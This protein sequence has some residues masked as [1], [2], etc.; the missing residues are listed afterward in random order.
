MSLAERVG[1]LFMVDCP[2]T[3]VAAATVRAI[4]KYHVG[5]VILDGNSELSNPATARITRQ[6][7]ALSPP[8]VGLFVAADQEGG[9]VQRL[10]GPGFSGIPSAVRQGTLAPAELRA[11][12]ARWGRELRSAG[13]NVN[14]APVLDT[15][16]AGFG[17]NPPIGDVNREFGHTTTAVTAHGIAVAR[18]FAD[19][20]IVATAK[21]FPG[22]GRVHANT[23]TAAGV[24][25]RV[26]VR[27]D[28]YLAPF[29]A[30]VR[31][32]VPFVMMSTAVYARIDPNRPA[33]FSPTIVTG[34]L[35]RR[36]GF[37]G[38]VISDD[39][40]RASQVAAYPAGARA[41]QF[42][43]AGGDLVITVD[44]GRIPAMTA[45][46]IGR[47]AADPDFARAV[48]NAALRVLT[49]KQSHGLL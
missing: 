6:L 45:A 20:G 12:A 31:A 42:V 34:M 32:G 21:H 28:P 26:T 2:S 35:R 3:G 36:L 41:V 22:L 5:S 47:A 49:A 7:Q 30:A 15:V 16:P 40:G 9:Q 11:R 33:A 24:T 14:L 44:P 1:Q 8:G 10:R 43:A 39:L 4:E 25:D 23:D 37:T 18:G 17:A 27:N 29:A 46:L 48:N 38:V 19:A 13:I